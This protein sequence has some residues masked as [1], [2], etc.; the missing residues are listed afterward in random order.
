MSVND[1]THPAV[2]AAASNLQALADGVRARRAGEPVDANPW[3]PFRP[4]HENWHDGWTS[5]DRF[6]QERSAR[7]AAP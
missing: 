2:V 6:M 5:E 7:E 1:N 3:T 4:E